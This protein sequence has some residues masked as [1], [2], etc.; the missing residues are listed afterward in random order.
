MYRPLSGLP[1]RR[2]ALFRPF[3]LPFP[4][5]ARVGLFPPP[6]SLL[7]RNPTPPSN[8]NRVSPISVRHMS[9]SASAELW[10]REGKRLPAWASFALQR[11]RGDRGRIQVRAGLRPRL[12]PADF[13]AQIGGGG[14]GFG[15][16]YSD[17]LLILGS[18]TWHLPH[19]DAGLGFL[20]GANALISGARSGHDVCICRDV[21]ADSY[22]FRDQALALQ[23]AV[24]DG[25]CVGHTTGSGF[26]LAENTRQRHA[27]T[28]FITGPEIDR[29]QGPSGQARPGV[30]A[31]VQVGGIVPKESPVLRHRGGVIVDKIGEVIEIHVDRADIAARSVERNAVA[32]AA[33]HINQVRL[34]G[35]RSGRNFKPPLTRFC[36]LWQRRE[37]RG[38]IGGILVAE[39]TLHK[40]RHDAP[41]LANSPHNLCG[42]QPTAGE[43]RPKC[44]LAS[45][46]MT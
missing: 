46:A 12:R 15:Q 43:I 34:S 10:D 40:G 14:C 5:K 38:Q 25:Q 18:A 39:L 26:P 41:R 36:R 3:S 6:L 20:V 11:R 9:N 28:D 4:V 16:R 19:S 13:T 21:K 42:A 24:C 44:T 1:W 45:V 8:R 2:P 35:R 29:P 22:A 23:A 27:G 30:V 32:L 31:H 7:N 17:A 33:A 37:V